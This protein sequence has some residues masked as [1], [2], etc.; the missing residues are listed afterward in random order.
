M[1]CSHDR[2][3]QFLQN[4]NG[5]LIPDQDIL[6]VIAPDYSIKGK[7]SFDFFSD[8]FSIFTRIDV[9]KKTC[10]VSKIESNDYGLDNDNLKQGLQFFKNAT[11]GLI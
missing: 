8:G 10:F 5:P 7:F 11:S 4:Y 9:K 1:L 3:V 6:L 2:S